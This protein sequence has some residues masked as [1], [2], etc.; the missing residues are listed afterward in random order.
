MHQLKKFLLSLFF[1]LVFCQSFFVTQAL[2][3][4]NDTKENFNTTIESTYDVASD[5]NTKVSHHLRITNKTPT[6]YLKQYALKTSYFG[7]QNI[8]VRSGSQN[9]PANIVSNENGTS[10]GITFENDAVGQG[11]V[12]DF[13]IEYNDP[14]IAL[15]AGKVL[16]IHIP[17][18]GDENSF[19]S[20]RAILLTPVIFGLPVRVTPELESSSFTQNGAKTVFNRPSGVSI[21]AIFGTEQNYKMTLRYNLENPTSNPAIAQIAL[22]PDTQYQKMHYHDLDPIPEEMKQDVDGN[23]IASYRIPAS[24]VVVASFF[25]IEVVANDV[26]GGLGEGKEA[27]ELRRLNNK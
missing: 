1:L 4:V 22:P 5:G 21:S 6:I 8:T 3:Q 9:I 12:R 20:N 14:D 10:I 26:F 24:S 13:Y 16:E 15:V 27:Q 17:Q 18:L 23:W 19:D 7:L 11:K 2:A 25:V